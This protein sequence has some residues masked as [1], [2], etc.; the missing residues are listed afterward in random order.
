MIF[1]MP[2]GI[3]DEAE[4]A[5]LCILVA[6]HQEATL[7]VV[8]LSA[9]PDDRHDLCHA[10]ALIGED[11]RRDDIVLRMTLIERPLILCPAFALGK[12]A[13]VDR[14]PGI[15]PSVADC[16]FGQGSLIYGEH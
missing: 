3:D 12:L 10:G 16:T 6:R 15:R 11:R 5:T 2:T 9:P 13:T 4:P 1:G 14:L 7:I 8:G